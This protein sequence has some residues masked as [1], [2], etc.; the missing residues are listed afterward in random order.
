MTQHR[1]MTQQEISD[2]ALKAFEL[3]DQGQHEECKRMLKQIPLPPYLAK[4]VKE[5]FEYFGE[6]FFEKYGFNTAEA[7]VEYGPDWLSR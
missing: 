1:L 6:D 4:F 2:L 3:K 7:E 5:H